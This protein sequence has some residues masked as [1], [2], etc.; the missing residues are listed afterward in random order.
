M[1]FLVALFLLKNPSIFKNSVFYR[2]ANGENGL[3][4]STAV[5]GDLV[6]K[7]TDGDGIPDWEE[8]LWGTDPTKKE[9]TPGIPDSVAISKLKASQGT[10]AG[11]TA[12]AD[13]KPENLTK[14]DQF[15]RELFATVASLN[16]NGAMDQTTV[17]KISSSLADHIKN[18]TPRKIYMLSDI[19]VTQ[20][21]SVASV[22]KYENAVN[23]LDNNLKKKYPTKGAVA[24]ILKRFIVDQNNIDITV[25]PELDPFIKQAEEG[26]NG[27]LKINVPSD[28]AQVHLDIINATER[29]MEN[30]SD[31]QSFDTDP[32][33]A[34]TGIS[35]Y[36]ENMNL[37]ASAFE[38]YINIMDKKLNS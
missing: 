1:L 19:K 5:V 24:D 2:S 9:T 21:N 26:V 17:D 4:Y 13:Q 27:M 38:K 33:V 34:M 7:D 11:T 8:S 30:E 35:K 37:Y 18:S 14:T 36:Q 6:N 20:D 22:K 23:S 3:I 10:S 28:L 12:T 16:Q 29:L 15:S 25:L 32:I 31:F